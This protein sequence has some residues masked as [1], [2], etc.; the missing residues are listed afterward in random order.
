MTS[1]EAKGGSLLSWLLPV[2]GLTLLAGGG[3]VMV[4]RQIVAEVKATLASEA[5]GLTKDPA[6]AKD[7]LPATETAVREL[8]PMVTNLSAPDGSVVRLQAAIIYNKVDAPR[9]DVLAAQIG[10]DTL[11]FLKTLT[12]TQLQGAEGLQQLREDLG[13]RAAMRSDGRVKDVLIEM[14]VVQ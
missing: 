7:I 2:F 11:A 10:D 12:L 8:A 9:A 14:L 4:A 5:K 1:T 3:G 6:K 13:E